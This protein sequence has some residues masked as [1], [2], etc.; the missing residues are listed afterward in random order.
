MTAQALAVTFFANLGWAS[1]VMLLV[2]AVR[3]PVAAWFGAGAAYALWLLPALRLVVPPM[4]SFAPDMPSLA[5]PETLV[6]WVNDA[7][8]LP[9]E[10]AAIPWLSLAV[11]LWA[12]GALALLAWQFIAYRRFIG[13]I[14]AGALSLGMHRGLEL[15]ESDA[16]EGPVALGLFQRRIVVPL[17]FAA[18]YTPTE[19]RLALDHEAIHHHRGDLWWNHLGLLVLAANWFNPVA[20]L[21]FRAFRADQEL[22]CDAAV[23]A[24]AGPGA[25][26]D[27]A[28]ALIKSASRPGLIATCPLNHADQL[29]R[30]LKMMKTHKASRL[31]LLGGVAAVGSLA[32]ISL[33]L[34]APGLA[35]EQA[36]PQAETPKQSEAAPT[37]ERREER[38]IIRTMHADGDHSDH[39][40]GGSTSGN[41]PEQSDRERRIIIMEHGGSGTGDHAAHGDSQVHAF[42]LHR[43]E[44]GAVALDGHQLENCDGGQASDVSEGDANNRTRVVVC[45]RGEGANPGQRAEHLQH[46]RDRLAQDS[47]LSAEQKARITAALDREIARLRGQ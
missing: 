4:P 26:L 28:R 35:A 45:T 21:A 11:A 19:R 36:T 33:A 44:G 5:P 38:V 47:E 12:A 17:D 13:E 46:A 27:Y 14:G 32:A 10:G 42:R 37:R 41:H 2:L 39:A 31:R 30:R 40:Q 18:R 24:S 34:G 29:K 22:A 3:R 9:A 23:A 6:V 43:G 25:R 20:W 7:A 8:P 15:V 1:L 16:V